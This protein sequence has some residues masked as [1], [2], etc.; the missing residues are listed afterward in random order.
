M[1]HTKI[2]TMAAT[3]QDTRSTCDGEGQN[4]GIIAIK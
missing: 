4:V 2:H 1:P 3:I